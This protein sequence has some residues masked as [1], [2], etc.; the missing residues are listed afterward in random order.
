M[1]YVIL[2]LII[3][4]CCDARH[5]PEDGIYAVA[6]NLPEYGSGTRELD[7][8]LKE[9]INSLNINYQGTVFVS[10]VV[11]STGTAGKYKVVRSENEELDSIAL[12]IFESLPPKW[13]AG[14]Y[15]GKPVNVKMVYP[16][17]FQ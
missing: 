14:T 17:K 10:F 11:D 5:V 4:F 16:V 12:K 13:T 8:M 3:A 15:D 6:E 7:S 1:R 2:L 9:E